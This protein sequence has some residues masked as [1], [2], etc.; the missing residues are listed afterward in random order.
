[1]NDCGNKLNWDAL[2]EA[3]FTQSEVK[4]KV[5]QLCP[6]LHDPTAYTV[7]GILQARILEWVAFPFSRASSQSR[8]WTQVSGIAGRFFTSW[9]TREAHINPKQHVFSIAA[10][11]LRGPQT[12]EH[13]RGPKQ[14][15]ILPP[16][17]QRLLGPGQNCGGDISLLA[18]LEL[19]QVS[20]CLF[21]LLFSAETRRG[22][23]A[24]F[25]NTWEPCS[26][27]QPQSIFQQ[28]RWP[29]TF[30][31]TKLTKSLRTSLAHQC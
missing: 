30:S 16:R 10:E 17:S 12:S 15:S 22:T 1:M 4:V 20:H 28:R 6:T 21:L 9:A 31:S 18:I 2:H 5:A 23:D 26:V 13:T 14:T 11:C 24:Q 3:T 25:P 8:D 27:S 29:P 7:H 19:L